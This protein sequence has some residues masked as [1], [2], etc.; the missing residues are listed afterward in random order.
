MPPACCPSHNLL[1]PPIVPHYLPIVFHYCP[2]P[3]TLSMAPQTQCLTLTYT[4]LPTLAQPS[5]Y[6]DPCHLPAVL[7]TVVLS[8]PF[9]LLT[10]LA[11]ILTHG[12]VFVTTEQAR[13]TNTEGECH[14]SVW[15]YLFLSNF[16]RAV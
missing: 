13:G 14:G 1:M 9:Y 15:K 12:T 5:H 3:L 6:T 8:L 2:L 10:V 4:Y 11:Q 16:E 7:W